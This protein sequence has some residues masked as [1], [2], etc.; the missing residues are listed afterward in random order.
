MDLFH[1]GDEDDDDDAF[2]SFFFGQSR[3]D[4]NGALCVV[5]MYAQLK[6]KVP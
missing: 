2:E 1:D 3:W 4:P 5:A 6:L